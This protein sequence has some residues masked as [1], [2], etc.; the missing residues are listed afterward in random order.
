[1][2]KIRELN[3][4]L[5]VAFDSIMR[6]LSISNASGELGISQP[7]VSNHLSRLRTI[8]DDNLFVRT[9]H[10]VLPTPFA[11]AIYPY[12]RT[13]LD[14]L[15]EGLENAGNFNPSTTERIFTII[16]T[17]IGE[18]TI[19]P[20]LMARIGSIAPG[21]TI[22]TLNLPPFE[23]AEALQTGAADMAVAYMPKLESCFSQRFIFNMDYIC[24]VRKGHPL[25]G[26]VITKDDFESATHIV[27]E[28]RGTGHYYLLEQNFE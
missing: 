15:K 20:D 14:A 23:V 13:A 7:T 12:V 10:G 25:A 9:S 26:K 24:L 22:R 11:E 8:L 21:V 6:N 28:A 1:M 27:A 17:D 3:F 2:K 19:L 4:K 18:V 16:M 5:L